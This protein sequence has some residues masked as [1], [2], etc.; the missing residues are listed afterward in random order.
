VIVADDAEIQFRIEPVE[1]GAFEARRRALLT[2]TNGSEFKTSIAWLIAVPAELDDLLVEVCRSESVL[3]T[4]E[5]DADKDVAQFL[6]AEGRLAEQSRERASDLLKAAL[7]NGTFVFRGMPR[8]V[9][10]TG[11]TLEVAARAQLAQAAAAVFPLL[12]LVPIRPGTDLAARFLTV[13][14]LDRITRDLDP[15]AFVV[16]TGGLPRIDKGNSALVEALRAFREKADQSGTGRLQGNALQD[17]FGGPPY[18]WSK[19]ATRYLFAAL[20]RSGEIEF[21][22]SGGVVQTA[23][24]LA[25][26]AVKSALAFNRVGISLRNVPPSV[27]ALERAAMN[28][29][30]MFGVEVLPLEEHIS[31]AVREHV[32]GLI[33]RIAALPDRLRLLELPGSGRAR[34]LLETAADLL[35]QDASNAVGLLGTVNCPVPRDAKWARAVV[36]VLMGAEA[37]VRLARD[38]KRELEELAR[39]F[40]GGGASLLSSEDVATID[41]VLASE[42]FHER[43]PGLRGALR[44]TL[45]RV[46]ARYRE[47]RAAVLSGTREALQR[48]EAM[49]EW[50][51][52][53]PEDREDIA[54]RFAAQTFPDAPGTGT[55]VAALRFLLAREIALPGLLTEAEVEVRR[56]V[57]APVVVPGE[58]VEQ[59]VSLLDLAPPDVLRS[60]EDLD[61]WLASLRTRLGELLGANKHVRVKR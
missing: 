51:Q 22:T 59:S 13:E 6:R 39:L 5:R 54:G 57:P 4:P 35:K 52:L 45:D 36:D 34:T 50:L 44:S 61:R 48:L 12:R 7:L 43:L 26:E 2:E 18:G 29:Q 14:R 23:G 49:P 47:R 55:E 56:R 24:P 28:L 8:P 21:H 38:I 46:V 16:T 9:I 60:A 20:L 3:G 19:D 40:P 27:E 41:E 17:F 37:D 1:P 15:L 33:E 11:A 25:Q 58:P 10:E 30:E 32:P 42:S 53:A 31:R